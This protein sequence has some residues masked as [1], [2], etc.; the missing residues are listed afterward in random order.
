MSNS[1]VNAPSE[2]LEVYSGQSGPQSQVCSERIA[3]EEALIVR[4]R[5]LI[6]RTCRFD[7]GPLWPLGT[8]KIFNRTGPE[9]PAKCQ[10]GKY[11]TLAPLT[12]RSEYAQV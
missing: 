9:N 4:R 1:S 5:R 12:S 2:Y 8:D 6:E 3:I 11:I 7:S 10:V